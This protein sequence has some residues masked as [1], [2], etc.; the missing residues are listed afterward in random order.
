MRDKAHYLDMMRQNPDASI[1]ISLAAKAIYAARYGDADDMSDGRE[2]TR[3]MM[4][5]YG[6]SIP[7]HELELLI[8]LQCHCH[9]CGNTWER[10]TTS[11]PLKCPN[12]GSAKWDS[13]RTGREP[14]PKP[15]TR[16]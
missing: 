7:A 16:E 1:G 6:D 13:P 10:R 15:K 4:G 12:C 11:K 14:G 9:R 5:K 3:E 2:L 8:M